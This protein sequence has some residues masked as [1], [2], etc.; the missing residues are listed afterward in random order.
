MSEPESLSLDGFD[1]GA[2]LGIPEPKPGTPA[3]TA[4]PEQGGIKVSHRMGARQLWRKAASEKALEDAIDWH[5]R[6]G[7][8][9]HCFSFGD[10]DSFSFFKMVLRQQPI[11]Y[12]AISTWCMAGE[13]VID[14]RKWHERGLVGRVDFFMGEI[15]KGSYPDVYAATKE[16][17]AECGGRHR[18]IR[19]PHGGPPHRKG[20]AKRGPEAPDLV[21]GGRSDSAGS[22]GEA[23]Q[24][25][26]P[27]SENSKSRSTRKK[28]S[29][30]CSHRRS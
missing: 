23:W 27:A 13:D 21:C 14:L 4:A 29:H 9:Y 25:G 5:W 20:T 12:A 6:E 7:D 16:F 11:R 15:F 10:V 19:G 28:P 3:K 24:V 18:R 22:E 2:A 26:P 1:L 30:F 8:S 17:I